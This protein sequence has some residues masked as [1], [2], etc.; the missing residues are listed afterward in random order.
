MPK[1]VDVLGRENVAALGQIAGA[2]LVQLTP[3]LIEALHEAID[4]KLASLKR[5]ANGAKPRF[6]ALVQ[7]EMGVYH[8]LKSSLTE[9]MKQASNSEAANVK[10]P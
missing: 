6:A 5:A 1:T 3:Q 9:A 4:L 2:A 8:G 7:E 10:V